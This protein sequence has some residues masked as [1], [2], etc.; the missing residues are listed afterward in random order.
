MPFKKYQLLAHILAQNKGLNG[1][2]L[3]RRWTPWGRLGRFGLRVELHKEP[4]GQL[5]FER[6][7]VGVIGFLFSSSLI[8]NFRFTR[9]ATEQR[10]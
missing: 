9:M 3:G 4:D 10:R 5:D 8:N 6:D 1:G 2:R 7:S